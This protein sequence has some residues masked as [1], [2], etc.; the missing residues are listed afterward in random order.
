MVTFDQ[1]KVSFTESRSD[2]NSQLFIPFCVEL[3]VQ[4]TDNDDTDSDDNSN[5]QV[6][7]PTSSPFITSNQASINSNRKRVKILHL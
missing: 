5:R 6:I 4:E 3:L 2:G 1:I 7:S